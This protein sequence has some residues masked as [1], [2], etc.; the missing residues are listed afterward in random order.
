MIEKTI[1][2]AAR[3]A[4]V[5]LEEHGWGQGFTY[6]S[7]GYCIGGAMN[8]ATGTT[9][10]N[11]WWMEPLAQVIREQYPDFLA[12]LE[13]QSPAGWLAGHPEGRLIAGWNDA[14]DRTKDEVLAVLEK[15][16]TKE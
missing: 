3:E 1:A 15:L 7:Q 8:R 4:A 16:A 14:E 5:L 12:R 11:S 2:Q 13:T 9:C 10:W 6:S